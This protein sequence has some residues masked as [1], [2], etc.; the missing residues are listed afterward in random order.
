LLYI[1]GT[2]SS[3]QQ[4][5]GIQIPLI[6]GPITEVCI[7]VSEVIP[8]QNGPKDPVRENE[9]YVLIENDSYVACPKIKYKENFRIKKFK[10]VV[11]K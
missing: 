2:F 9:K 11:I 5:H 4:Y 1:K 6:K 7:I 3:I 8:S 10:Y